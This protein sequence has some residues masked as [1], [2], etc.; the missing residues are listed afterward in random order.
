MGIDESLDKLILLTQKRDELH[1]DFL[2]HILLM[3]SSLLGILVA[4]HTGS[5]EHVYSYICY[6]LG[7]GLLC[8]G[9][10]LLS[11]TL[12]ARVLSLN[13]QV[14]DSAA[15]ILQQIRTNAP[16]GELNVLY[17]PRWSVFFERVAYVSFCL[18]LV[19]LT[20]Y[21]ILSGYHFW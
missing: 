3:A 10:L 2:K 9:I 17:L 6:C 15:D 14:K 4:L 7:V 13:R 11:S 18:S 19:F 20:A 8:C 21:A 12:Y 5:T 16:Q 1:Y